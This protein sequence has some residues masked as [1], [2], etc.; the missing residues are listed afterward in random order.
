MNHDVPEFAFGQQIPTAEALVVYAWD[1]IVPRLPKAVRLES[2][3]I[4]E[5]PYLHAEYR[6]EQ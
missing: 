2:V 1:R 6:G 5:E 4:Q 3:R